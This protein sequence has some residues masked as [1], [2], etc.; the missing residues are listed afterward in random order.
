M[1]FNTIVPQSQYFIPPKY[2]TGASKFWLK[3]LGYNP[4]G[5]RNIWGNIMS[6]T[7]LG[8]GVLAN[9]LSQK[10][11]SN[12]NADDTAQNVSDLTAANMAMLKRNIGIAKA[13]GGGFAGN[14]EMIMSGVNDTIG[15]VAQQIASPNKPEGEELQNSYYYKDGG[16]TTKPYPESS[17]KEDIAM[18]D[19]E[20]GIKVG[21]MRYGE[22]IFD[23][24]ANK[25]MIALAKKNKL[26]ELGAFVVKELETHKDTNMEGVKKY[27]KGGEVPKNIVVIAHKFINNQKLT[28]DET[29]QFLQFKKNNVKWYDKS[30]SKEIAN[31]IVSD[32]N[33]NGELT[34]KG[35]KEMQSNNTEDLKS[36]WKTYLNKN[37]FNNIENAPT[38]E[39]WKKSNTTMK[40]KL[41]FSPLLKNTTTVAPTQTTQKP[42]SQTTTPKSPSQL[43]KNSYKASQGV[44]NP[45]ALSDVSFVDEGYKNNYSSYGTK[46]NYDKYLSYIGTLSDA[47]IKDAFKGTKYENYSTEKLKQLGTDKKI[48]FVHSKLFDKYI[49]AASTDVPNTTTQSQTI[50][51]VDES[52]KKIPF[53]VEN[54]P[55][56]KDGKVPRVGTANKGQ[57]AIGGVNSGD[58]TENKI[59][60]SLGKV[61][62]YLDYAMEAGKAIFGAMGVKKPMPSWEIPEN[63]KQY[64]R[65]SEINSKIGFLPNERDILQNNLDRERGFSVEAIRQ[66]VG[67]GGSAGSVLAALDGVNRNTS[68]ANNDIAL[69]DAMLQRQNFDKYGNVL[70]T[71]NG[72]DRTQ[73]EDAFGVAAQSQQAYAAL[74]NSG[75]QGMLDKTQYEQAYGKNSNYQKLQDALLEE[76]NLKLAALKNKGIAVEPYSTPTQETIQAWNS[77]E[78]NVAKELYDKNPTYFKNYPKTWGE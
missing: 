52:T 1:E 10:I 57:S 54:F 20:T 22:R 61:S 48:G 49:A 12:N 8:G 26:K 33:I 29:A 15:G 4:S 68:L 7:S 35:A 28:P 38:F 74:M 70:T 69:K 19:K 31:K 42:L 3:A 21:E 78:P 36:Q 73:F 6:N 41:E 30:S 45:T 58:A 25:T 23:Q 64:V 71:N 34:N 62:N 2:A 43:I 11:A 40:G 65:D 5:G 59:G 13:V 66:T 37:Y 75:I 76:Q 27:A 17:N 72:Y 60:D 53:G 55:F 47:Q 50:Q 44:T 18:Y 77:I 9:K 67:G 39:E 56:T 24:T 46:E 14:P 16:Q 32:Y 51:S 63:W